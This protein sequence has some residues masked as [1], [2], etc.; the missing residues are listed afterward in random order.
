VHEGAARM[1][2]L[3]D[4][5]EDDLDLVRVVLLD[6]GDDRVVDGGEELLGELGDCRQSLALGFL[7][8]VVV[9]VVRGWRGSLRGRR[10]PSL[11][12]FRV[13]N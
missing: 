2:W 7:V 4:L 5:A 1:P 8:V 13:S 3:D 10:S 9:V 12:C 11:D 6:A